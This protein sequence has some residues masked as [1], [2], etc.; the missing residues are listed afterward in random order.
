ML[1]IFNKN[2]QQLG[3]KFRWLV[4]R[5][6]K[7]KVIIKRFGKLNSITQ[8]ISNT[9][10]SAAIHPNNHLGKSETPIRIATFN[11]A[12]FSMAPAV[13]EL[14]EKASSFDYGEDE[15]DYSS[16]LHEQFRN[17]IKITEIRKIKVKS[18]NQF[19]RQRDLTEAK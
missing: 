12:L 11:A 10:G 15:Q 1:S 16:K 18:F 19:T 13:P 9:N 6:S 5:R 7:L 17:C 8:D 4:H 14:T 2:L 3:S